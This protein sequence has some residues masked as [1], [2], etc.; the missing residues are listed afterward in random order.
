[1]PLSLLADK[2]HLGRIP[3]LVIVGLQTD[4]VREREPVLARRRVSGAPERD[5]V[6]L[7]T[8]PGVA[9]VQ[10]TAMQSATG[11]CGA[12][13]VA[14]QANH[15]SAVQVPARRQQAWGYGQLEMVAQVVPGPCH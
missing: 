5:S 7:G 6:P 2:T 15:G 1:M 9:A 10:S 14:R 3:P 12:P 11:P 4:Q 13:R 8:A